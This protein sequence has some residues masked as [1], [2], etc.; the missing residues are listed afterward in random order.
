[1]PT[2]VWGQIESWLGL[3]RYLNGDFGFRTGSAYEIHRLVRLCWNSI[4]NYVTSLNQNIHAG[5][6]GTIHADCSCLLEPQTSLIR[7]GIRDL[8][9]K[10]FP[11]EVMLMEAALGL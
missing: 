10:N 8:E 7:Y 4:A 11:K 9:K 5:C 3:M 6:L 1:M 2:V